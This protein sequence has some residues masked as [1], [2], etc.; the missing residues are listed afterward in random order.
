MVNHQ[1][2]SL[3]PNKV[4]A[5]FVVEDL[6]AEGELLCHQSV[7]DNPRAEDVILGAD[8]DFLFG[9]LRLD[10]EKGVIC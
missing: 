1:H 8:L 3:Q 7:H 2:L 9:N 5:R 10:G 4:L 6:I